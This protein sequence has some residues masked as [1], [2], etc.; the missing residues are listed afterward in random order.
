MRVLVCGDLAADER[1]I[2]RAWLKAGERSSLCRGARG[3]GVT[4]IIGERVNPWLLWVVLTTLLLALSYCFFEARRAPNHMV[5]P[6]ENAPLH[7]Q[8]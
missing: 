4:M 6:K 7:E 1:V 5:A 3:L 8:K 2:D